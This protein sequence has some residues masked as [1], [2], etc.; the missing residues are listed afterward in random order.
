[1]DIIGIGRSFIDNILAG[2]IVR[3]GSTITQQLARDLYLN[4]E[5]TLDRKIKEAYIALKMN[6]ALTKDEILE[7]YLNRIFLGQNSYGIQSASQTYFSKDV[8][9]LTIGE[10]AALASLPQAPSEYAL[11]NTLP[12]ESIDDSSLIIE[13]V[14][15]NDEKYFAVY[16]SA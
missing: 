13:E 2:G 15:I 7:I 14:E 1:I 12:P 6:E 10:A 3:G 16:N 11:Y 8:S 9:E 5:T 4:D